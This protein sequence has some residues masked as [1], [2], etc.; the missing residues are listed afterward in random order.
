[1][2]SSFCPALSERALDQYFKMSVCVSVCLCVC[3]SV[4]YFKASDWSKISWRRGGYWGGW[5]RQGPQ[6]CCSMKQR[7]AA[8]SFAPLRHFLS[9]ICENLIFW[10]WL[11]HTTLRYAT[12]TKLLSTPIKNFY[13]S[14]CTWRWTYSALWYF[15]YSALG[16]IY[17]YEVFVTCPWCQSTFTVWSHVEFLLKFNWDM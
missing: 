11:S 16:I 1:M 9:L 3:L 13:S 7:K 10:V 17:L 2:K 8:L 15:L 12:S 14:C 6:I 4:T 5:A